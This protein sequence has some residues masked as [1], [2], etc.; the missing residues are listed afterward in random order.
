MWMIV[1][2]ALAAPVPVPMQGSL[3][4]AAG[5][6][7]AGS[8]PV[9][10]RV[11]RAGTSA[12]EVSVT[13]TVSFAN[14]VFA[15]TVS[16]EPA[17]L[18]NADLMVAMTVGGVETAAVPVGWAPRAG[19]AVEAGSATQATN[20]AQLGGVAA[21]QF[22]RSP[23]GVP[24]ADV[25]GEPAEIS[26]AAA[27]LTYI[28]TNAYDTLS[29]LTTALSGTYAA[30]TN[31]TI[32]GDLTLSAGTVKLGTDTGDACTDSAHYG[33]IRWNGSAF[34]GCTSAGWSALGGG[35]ATSIVLPTSSATSCTTAGELV[36][37][38]GSVR[39]CN[40]SSY[41]TLSP[42]SVIVETGSGRAWSDGRYARSCKEYRTP[43]DGTRVYAGATGDG[44][45]R[46]DPDGDQSVSF[47]VFCDM[48]TDG[49]GWTVFHSVTG[50]DG[51][52]PMVSDTEA[53][54]DPATFG[55]YNLNRAKKVAIAS[56][57][58]ETLFLRNSGPWLKMNRAA[59][60]S[61]LN[62]ATQHADY[63]AITYTAR[64]G[65]TATGGVA[66]WANFNISGGGDFGATVSGFDHH[67][68]SYYHLNTSCVS[69]YLYSYS[70]ANDGDAGYDVNTALGDWSATAS[71]DSAEGGSLTFR[72]AMR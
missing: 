40:G 69:S 34:Q 23:T 32:T 20:A 56:V 9:T 41:I 49:G 45:Y 28:Q 6:P 54:G 5:V 46:I 39:V 52:Q 8:H 2:L 58:S 33:R 55:H 37:N 21:A 65:T 68:S 14:G 67:S 11:F 35:A 44:T 51:Q 36:Y 48:T 53:T 63:S 64:N 15:A 38:S 16:L 66:G 31:P 3:T 19:Y 1:G 72:S 59:F 24:W 4:D 30:A 7:V 50:A 57:S 29:D 12:G 71:C 70:L 61:N 42:T 62:I 47:L 43:T 60:D 17:L 22:Y 27:L 10:F 25:T 26:S 13:E 18:A